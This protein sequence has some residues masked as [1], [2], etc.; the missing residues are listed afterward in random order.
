MIF[1][2]ISFFCNKKSEN[3]LVYFYVYY[4]NSKFG[5][6][7]PKM[8]LKLTLTCNHVSPKSCS[9]PLSYQ[10]YLSGCIRELLHSGEHEIALWLK[11]K[12]FTLSHPFGLY[13]FSM[14]HIPDYEIKME[15]III[16]SDRLHF[17]LSV[18]PLPVSTLD[19]ISFL[20]DKTIA[21][22][23][24]ISKISFIIEKI[25]TMPLP[26]FSNHMQFQTLSPVLVSFRAPH[27]PQS[28]SFLFP[29]GNKYK[30]LFFSS[31]TAKYQKAKQIFELPLLPD[32]MQNEL[33]IKNDISPRPAQLSAISL[34]E[35]RV[36]GYMYSFNI[37]A[38]AALI[39]L[40]YFSGFGEHCN[41]GFGCCKVIF[42]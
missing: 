37:K 20:K 14:F 2:P 27:T 31:L 12:G 42:E 10:Y 9:L 17:Y 28:A 15:R 11:T 33:E 26:E 41:T 29:K 39:R 13:T 18:Y 34:P 22:K 16:K 36:R 6:T 32:H 38:P 24:N 5:K 35:A 25:E 3:T 30:R 1:C 23:D 19:F 4:K 8:R 7:L 40:G 21:I